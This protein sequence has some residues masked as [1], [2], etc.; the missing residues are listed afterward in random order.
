MMKASNSLFIQMFLV[1]ELVLKFYLD[2]ILQS[3]I[4]TVWIIKFVVT[5]F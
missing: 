1:V 4:F 3:K 2:K 5:K